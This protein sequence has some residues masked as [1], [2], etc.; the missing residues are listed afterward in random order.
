[1]CSC[2]CTSIES[3]P[4]SSLWAVLSTLTM[5]ASIA[6][7]RRSSG[8]MYDEGRSLRFS[9]VPVARRDRRHGVPEFL[10]LLFLHNLQ[11]AVHLVFPVPLPAPGLRVGRASGGREEPALNST[12]GR[13]SLWV[14]GQFPG[15]TSGGSRTRAGCPVVPPRAEKAERR[16]S[17]NCGGCVGRHAAVRSAAPLVEPAG[18][19]QRDRWRTAKGLSFSGVSASTHS[20]AVGRALDPNALRQ[21]C[22]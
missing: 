22:A 12:R 14:A 3:S 19:E 6:I 18:P 1:M 13:A 9:R 5:A 4:R 10:R 7:P 21:T 17:N 2:N 20:S 8:S 11:E 15:P 16:D